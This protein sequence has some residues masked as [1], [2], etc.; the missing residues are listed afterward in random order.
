MTTPTAPS[1]DPTTEAPDLIGIGSQSLVDRSKALGLTWTRKL[2]TVDNGTVPGDCRI[3]IDGDS[4]STSSVSLLGRLPRG[5]R[6]YVDV[7]PPAAT[8]VVGYAAPNISL[9][10]GV[11]AR[12][13]STGNSAA[14]GAEAVVLTIKN[15][16]FRAG[17]AYAFSINSDVSSSVANIGTYQIRYPNLAG[18]I[19]AIPWQGPAAV[20]AQNN[21]GVNKTI[22]AKRR[23]AS[24]D[25][26][27]DVVLTLSA[28]AGTI[29]AQGG[30][31]FVRYFQIEDV[32]D[33]TLF[34]LCFAL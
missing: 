31:T 21:D 28:T 2:A 18:T 16:L 13:E 26:L 14:V 15:C 3:F 6:V 12:D 7:T 30:A 19:I 11:I 9:P 22:Y 32:G 5:T 33:E 34:P 1:A 29:T 10:W 23:L 20:G 27:S 24:G 25:L 17:R 8:F 4:V